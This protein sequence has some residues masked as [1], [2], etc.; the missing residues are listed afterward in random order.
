MNILELG[1][2][3]RWSEIRRKNRL[4]DQGVHLN[5]QVVDLARD[6][7]G[8]RGNQ[9]VERFGEIVRKVSKRSLRSKRSHD[10]DQNDTLRVELEDLGPLGPPGAGLAHHHTELPR[11]VYRE[12]ECV[13]GQTV[14]EEAEI[15]S[16]DGG[17]D[18]D[19]SWGHVQ[20]HSSHMTS[21]VQPY[22]GFK[23]RGQQ[24]GKADPGDYVIDMDASRGEHASHAEAKIK[25]ADPDGSV[26]REQ[27]G[28]HMT[29]KVKPADLESER[30]SR[31]HGAHMQESR[32]KPANVGFEDVDLGGK[33]GRKDSKTVKQD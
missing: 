6:E 9:S 23:K 3:T 7:I 20:E 12:R 13:M 22:G 17:S 11:E 31:E 5:R 33:S 32:V 26:H 2:L 25:P 18:D 24:G 8:R 27:H 14:P 28:A 30:F 16:T 1:S 21:K 19:Y 4:I 29:G 15:S 10:S